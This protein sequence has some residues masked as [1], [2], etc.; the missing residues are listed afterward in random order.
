[1]DTRF[2]RPA[3]IFAAVAVGTIAA[4]FLMDPG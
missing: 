3:A 4:M 1:M 2:G